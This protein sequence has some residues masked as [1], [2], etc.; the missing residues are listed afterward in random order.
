[1]VDGVGEI[2]AERRDGSRG[3]NGR[4]A[5]TGAAGFVGS[6]APDGLLAE[7]HAVVGRDSFQLKRR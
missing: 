5:V 3:V 6:R 7:G 1:V 4:I 2:R